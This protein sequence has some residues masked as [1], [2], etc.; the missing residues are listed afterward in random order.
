MWVDIDTVI[1]D[2]TFSLP[3]DRFVGKDFITWGNQTRILAGDPLNGTIPRLYAKRTPQFAFCC[4]LWSLACK[5]HHIRKTEGLQM[6]GLTDGSLSRPVLLLVF[7]LWSKH[8]SAFGCP[9]QS[10]ACFVHGIKLFVGHANTWSLQTRFQPSIC[11]RN[12][13]KRVATL[14]AQNLMTR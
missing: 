8:I 6:P 10:I 11:K 2:V 1:I 9:Q 4:L 14:F 12:S 7:A 3:F 5:S 13:T